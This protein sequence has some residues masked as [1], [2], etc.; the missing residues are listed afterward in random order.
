[1]FNS[2]TLSKLNRFSYAIAKQIE[3][4]LKC[5]FIGKS[6]NGDCKAE[7]REFLRKYSKELS[8]DHHINVSNI[9]KT[10]KQLKFVV[11]S[12]AYKLRDVA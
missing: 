3:H 10:S 12:I 8:R 11:G 1:M 2:K 7:V 4:G 5:G 9:L 6:T